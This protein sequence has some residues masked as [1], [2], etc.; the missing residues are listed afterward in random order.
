MGGGAVYMYIL[1]LDYTVFNLKM[2]LK[3][4]RRHLIR[5][6][7]W[8]SGEEKTVHW[9]EIF[10]KKIFYIVFANKRL[11]TKKSYLISRGV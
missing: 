5:I 11:L 6:I 3:L 8:S 4:I 10:D 2:V 7:H 9:G 1:P